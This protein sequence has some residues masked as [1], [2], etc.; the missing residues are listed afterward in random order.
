M[1]YFFNMIAIVRNIFTDNFSFRKSLK[2][3]AMHEWTRATV[4]NLEFK[5]KN[6]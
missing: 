2:Y 1:C 5:N 6:D 3:N 4:Q